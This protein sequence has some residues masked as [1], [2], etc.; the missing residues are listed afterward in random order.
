MVM[1]E[2][3]EFSEKI[4]RRLFQQ[5]KEKAQKLLQVDTQMKQLLEKRERFNTTASR[6]LT[7]V[8][9]PRMQELSRNFDNATLQEL[10]KVAGFL[11]ICGFSPTDRF[12]ATVSLGIDISPSGNYER[13]DIH[14][15]IEVNPAL[16]EYMRYDGRTFKL[17]SPTF[18]EEIG[19]WVESKIFDFLE[20][21][22]L[23]ETHPEYQKENYVI[24]PVCQMRIPR[25]QAVA[26]IEQKG[27]AIYFCSEV[28]KEAFLKEST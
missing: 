20:T 11:C 23:L 3:G 14:Y 13:L 19:Q 4:Q 10:D 7:A 1:A 28:C 15:N 12:P 24:D 26:K 21:Y 17:E 8:V 5:A 16:M 2:I 9:Y 6:I 18:E 22:L 27:R 25:A